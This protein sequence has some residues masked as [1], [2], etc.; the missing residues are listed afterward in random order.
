MFEYLIVLIIVFLITLT[1]E[2]THRVHL[3]HNLKERIYITLMF[4]A[5][6]VTWDSWAI[7]REH[8]TFSSGKNIGVI[9]GL[10]PLEEYLFALIIPYL[11]ITL[12]KIVDSKFKK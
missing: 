12:Y 9:I 3:Y 8:W 4:F 5:I 10:M 7:Y 11:I 6:S 1:L 2:K